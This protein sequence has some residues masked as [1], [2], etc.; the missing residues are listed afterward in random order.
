MAETIGEVAARYGLPT[1]VLRHWEEAG[2]LQPARTSS[3]HRRYSA[4]HDAQIELIQ[5][6]KV[7][8][9]SLE[10]IAIMLHGPSGQRRPILLQ[11]IAELKRTA[12]EVQAAQ[13]LLHHVLHCRAP[14]SCPECTHPHVSFD[15]P[16]DGSAVS[17]TAGRTDHT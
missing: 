2:A 5:C 14:G 10:H 4:E 7:A 9:L 13:R 17:T 15:F 16:H 6:G 3:G 8:G 12:M 1:H 11:Q